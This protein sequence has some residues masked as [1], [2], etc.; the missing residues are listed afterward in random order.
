MGADPNKILLNVRT[1]GWPL[2]S[3]F[4]A[5]VVILRLVTRFIH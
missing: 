5:V 2:L 1:E 4:I 3:G